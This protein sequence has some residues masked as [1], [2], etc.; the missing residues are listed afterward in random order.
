MVRRIFRIIYFDRCFDLLDTLQS[1]HTQPLKP[2]D[3]KRLLSF[4]NCATELECP[5]KT[6]HSVQ[7]RQSHGMWYL[8]SFTA[9]HFPS[10][11]PRSTPSVNHSTQSSSSLSRGGCSTAVRTKFIGIRNAAVLTKDFV[12]VLTTSQIIGECSVNLVKYF[13]VFS[14][15]LVPNFRF[16]ECNER[17]DEINRKKL[18]QEIK[19]NSRIDLDILSQSNSVLNESKLVWFSKRQI[20][21]NN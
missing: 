12:A 11:I 5:W 20:A 13:F 9:A 14:F 10:L 19:A 7:M 4:L 8:T 3:W 17:G 2:N 16:W 18:Q 1:N 6:C 21:N 15:N